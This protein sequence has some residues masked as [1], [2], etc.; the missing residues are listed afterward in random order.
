MPRNRH[1]SAQYGNRFSPSSPSGVCAAPHLPAGILSPYSDGE[2]DALIDD[3]ASR[4]HCKKGAGA[5]VSPF[6]PLLYAIG[7]THPEHRAWLRT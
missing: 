6:S 2:R 7:F 4:R 5:A 1:G 3:F